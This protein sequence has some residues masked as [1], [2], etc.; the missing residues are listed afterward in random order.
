MRI[1]DDL[2]GSDIKISQI[3]YASEI[4]FIFVSE[5]SLTNYD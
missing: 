3:L 1:E 5:H 4:L 2:A